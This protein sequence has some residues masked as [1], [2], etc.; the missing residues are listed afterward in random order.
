MAKARL[1]NSSGSQTAR[2]YKCVNRWPSVRSRP[3]APSQLLSQAGLFFREPF[4]FAHFFAL[5]ATR[6]G[7]RRRQYMLPIETSSCKSGRTSERDI[8][9]TW[10]KIGK[11]RKLCI[12]NGKKPVLGSVYLPSAGFLLSASGSGMTL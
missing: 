2:R 11:R 9:G 8:A 5:T 4:V 1:E 12:G 6:L 3:L 10:R 7:T